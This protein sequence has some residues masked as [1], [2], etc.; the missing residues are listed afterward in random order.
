MRKEVLMMWSIEEIKEILERKY[1]IKLLRVT[2][3]KDNGNLI[4]EIDMKNSGVS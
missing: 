1:N 2:F 4:G 3:D